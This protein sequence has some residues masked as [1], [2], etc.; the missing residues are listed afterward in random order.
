M[1]RPAATIVGPATSAG[2][3]RV[4]QRRD[5][6]DFGTEVAHCRE[7]CFQRAARVADADEQI[8]LDV[9]IVLLQP[10]PHLVVVVEDVDVHVDQARQHELLAQ[11]DEPCA[12]FRRDQAV[13]DGFDATV[14]HDDRRR[15]AR[16]LAGTIEQSA[17]V[18]VDHGLRCGLRERLDAGRRD[19]KG[20][21]ERA[22]RESHVGLPGAAPGRSAAARL[23]YLSRHRAARP[24]R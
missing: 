13:A 16:R 22:R 4:A 17:G 1:L 15:A 5:A 8:V 9:A 19:E 24:A 6:A 7:A 12:A 14:A 2:E 21:Q 23:A 18:D 3:N 11:I 20:N 10:R